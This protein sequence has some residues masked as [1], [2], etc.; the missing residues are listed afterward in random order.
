LKLK[1]LLI[2]LL[3]I[4][5]IILLSPTHSAQGP[6]PIV[7]SNVELVTVDESFAAITWVTNLPANTVVQWGETEDLSEEEVVDESE[8]YHMGK[9]SGLKQGTSY[10]YRVGSGGRFSGI[11][12]FATL[13][14][15]DGK[16]ELKFALVAD[17]HYDV[18]GRNTA[19]GY[20]NGDGPRIVE[21]LVTE[22]NQDSSIE[23]VVTLGDLT[24]GAEADYFGFV[25]TMN[26]LNVPWYPLLGNS[27]KSDP[28]WA[29]Y[30][31][32][33][34]GKDDTYYSVDSGGYHIIILD[35]AIY[36]QIYGTIDDVQFAWLM[37]IQKIN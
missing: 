13:T 2:G 30:Y 3:I 34:T 19:S 11:S 36:D 16:F 5:L 12:S 24:N 35:S 25:N 4:T 6:S 28:N 27:D 21:S 31:Y 14:P 7:L 10:Y 20:M 32:N 29:N 26:N 22:I 18:D 23:F 37:K 1:K 17:S 9:I 8:L 15:P 33:S